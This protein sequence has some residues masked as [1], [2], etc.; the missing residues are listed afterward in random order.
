MLKNKKDSLDRCLF[1]MSGQYALSVACGDSSP[2]GGAFEH[3][4]RGML[5]KNIFYKASSAE[6]GSQPY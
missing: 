5:S 4:N 1:C 3:V 6:A 2:S